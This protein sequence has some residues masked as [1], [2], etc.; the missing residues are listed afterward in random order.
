MFSWSWVSKFQRNKEQGSKQCPGN[1]LTSW[2]RI[3]QVKYHLHSLWMLENFMLK[4]KSCTHPSIVYLQ[5]TQILCYTKEREMIILLFLERHSESVSNMAR[6]FRKATLFVHELKPVG[7]R[8]IA[9]A[10]SWLFS[11]KCKGVTSLNSCADL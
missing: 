2:Q 3:L 4:S 9:K 6:G 10:F 5:P 1:I 7:A 8:K 11:L